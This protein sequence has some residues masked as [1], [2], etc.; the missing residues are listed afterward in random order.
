M[1]FISSLEHHA[2]SLHITAPLHTQ[3][4]HRRAGRHISIRFLFV[5]LYANKTTLE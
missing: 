1:A 5:T 3:R 2:P 4:P